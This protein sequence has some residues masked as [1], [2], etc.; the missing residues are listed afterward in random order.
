[1]AT[2][3][4]ESLLPDQRSNPYPLHWK[5]RSQPLDCQGGPALYQ[6][7]I[8]AS[9]LVPLLVLIQLP[10]YLWISH[11]QIEKVNCP[12]QFNIRDLSIC[13]FWYLWGPRDQTLRSQRQ[14]CGAWWLGLWRLSSQSWILHSATYYYVALGFLSSSL[15]FGFYHFKMVMMWPVSQ[16]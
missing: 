1:M 8:R 16:G 11:P 6:N 13:K 9:S 4:V 5:V 7:S 14:D 10:S 12:A 2:R 15:C 3:H